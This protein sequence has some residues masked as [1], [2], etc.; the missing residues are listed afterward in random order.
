M[1]K[2]GLLLSTTPEYSCPSKDPLSLPFRLWKEGEEKSFRP[3][4]QKLTTNKTKNDRWYQ[5]IHQI[6][7]VL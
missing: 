5:D 4:T 7:L 1:P 6:I 3:M 2:L